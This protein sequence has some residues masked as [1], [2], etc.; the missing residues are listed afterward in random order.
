MSMQGDVISWENTAWMLVGRKQISEREVLITSHL[1][2]V[3]N[4]NKITRLWILR[5]QSA[6]CQQQA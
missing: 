5:L 6:K 2:C 1:Q 4:R 3:A